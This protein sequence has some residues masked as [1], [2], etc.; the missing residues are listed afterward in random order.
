MT[1]FWTGAACLITRSRGFRAALALAIGVN[2][3]LTAGD[4]WASCYALKAFRI[5][6]GAH[7]TFW[8][9]PYENGAS[10]SNLARSP[11]TE[12]GK[13]REKKLVAWRSLG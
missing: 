13:A 12:A 3:T 10:E 1:P 8:Q 7:V 5:V 4:S 6:L 2:S 11:G 9:Q